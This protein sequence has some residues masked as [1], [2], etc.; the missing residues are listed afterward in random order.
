MPCC[1]ISSIA[2]TGTASSPT[3][4]RTVVA[5]R[6]ERGHHPPDLGQEERARVAAGVPSEGLPALADHDRAGW[7]NVKYPQIDFQ[8]DRLLLAPQAEAQARQ[9]GRSRSRAAAH[10]REA[11]RAA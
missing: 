8:D 6:A 2:H 3:S 5:A 11:G 9:P 1:R 7:A 10:L 4:S